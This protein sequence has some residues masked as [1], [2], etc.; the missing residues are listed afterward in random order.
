MKTRFPTAGAVGNHGETHKHGSTGARALVDAL[1]S[2]AVL[3]TGGVLLPGTKLE[4]DL[5]VR[6]HVPHLSGPFGPGLLLSSHVP[7]PEE[8]IGRR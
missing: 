4:G 3:L 7:G 6:V 2:E 5:C 8:D 1:G